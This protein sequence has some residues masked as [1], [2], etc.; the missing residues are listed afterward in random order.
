[1]HQRFQFLHIFFD[2]KFL[3][4]EIFGEGR[5]KSSS[6]QQKN[7]IFQCVKCIQASLKKLLKASLWL[8]RLSILK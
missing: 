3:D 6:Y 7:L 1:M 5:P 8:L 2:L 4:I